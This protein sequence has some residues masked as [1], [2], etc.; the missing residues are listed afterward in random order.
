MRGF[1][2]CRLDQ[3]AV[4]AAGHCRS[5]NT[6]GVIYLVPSMGGGTFRA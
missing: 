6:G 2:T 4:L 1:A 3:T 5:L